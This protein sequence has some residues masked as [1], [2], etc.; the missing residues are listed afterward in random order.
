MT[1][2]R[3]FRDIIRRAMDVPR[4]VGA[5]IGQRPAYRLAEGSCEPIL[6]ILVEERAEGD[7]IRLTGLFN[8]ECRRQVEII[9]VGRIVALECDR[10]KF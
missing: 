9:E 6:T 3:G 4:V 5:G 7:E 2:S 10:S 8:R 1:P